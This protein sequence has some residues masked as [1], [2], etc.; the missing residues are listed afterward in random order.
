[1]NHNSHTAKLTF[2][3][4]GHNDSDLAYC[5]STLARFGVFVR[6]C[7]PLIRVSARA[8]Q[9][10]YAMATASSVVAMLTKLADLLDRS[11]WSDEQA[12]SLQ[13]RK[14][15]SFAAMITSLPT[16][17]ETDASSILDAS[18]ESSWPSRMACKRCHNRSSC[19]CCKH[20]DCRDQQEDANADQPHKLP[21][22]GGLVRSVESGVVVLNVGVMHLR[23]SPGHRGVQPSRANR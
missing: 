23:P 15:V 21:N 22:A 7:I 11:D 20:R 8:I 19:D 2:N 9:A 5:P 12:A 10:L 6:V 17:N 18:S 1:M 16:F 13:Q 3:D 4:V 14:A